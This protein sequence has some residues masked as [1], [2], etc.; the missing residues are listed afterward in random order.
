MFTSGRC[1]SPDA[2]DPQ[3]SG[4]DVFGIEPPDGRT[5]RTCNS[6]FGAADASMWALLADSP[7][8]AVLKSTWPS[9]ETWG[10]VQERSDLRPSTILR[11]LY[12]KT[13]CL[14]V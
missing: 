9:Q 2:D 12:C 7:G 4:A 11:Q 13:L 1:A 10:F 6:Q 14:T 5:Q 3:G 8:G